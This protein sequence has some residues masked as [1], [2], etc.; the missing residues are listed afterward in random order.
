MVFG[1]YHGW[2][3]EGWGGWMKQD[4]ELLKKLN[5]FP[6]NTGAIRYSTLNGII[7]DWFIG[8]D[9]RRDN[10]ETLRNHLLDNIPGATFL[11]WAKK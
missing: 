10:E 2:T 8:A 5:A 9:K 11:G 6:K 4:K 7:K 3:A 1:N